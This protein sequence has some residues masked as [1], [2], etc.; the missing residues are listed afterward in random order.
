MRVPTLFRAEVIVYK[1]CATNRMRATSSVM[2]SSNVIA[3]KQVLARRWVFFSLSFD[4]SLSKRA[5]SDCTGAA[6]AACAVSQRGNGVSSANSNL[7]ICIILRFFVARYVNSEITLPSHLIH[8]TLFDRRDHEATSYGVS[9][10]ME[11][12][13]QFIKNTCGHVLGVE[14]L[15]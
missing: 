4:S 11:P 9:A 6:A 8:L 3:I 5:R 7:N 12:F 10:Y 13:C 15:E 2:V 1:A 14:C